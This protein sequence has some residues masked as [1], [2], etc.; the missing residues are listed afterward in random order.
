M[1]VSVEIGHYYFR[2]LI[3]GVLHVCIDRH[4]FVGVSSWYDCETR[5]SIEWV[6]KTNTFRTGYD[7][8]DKWK[9]ILKAVNENL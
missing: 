2:L 1:K 4:E 6:T 5:C 3:D 7:S 9:A 8:V